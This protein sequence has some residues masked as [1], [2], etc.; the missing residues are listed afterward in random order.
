MKV[1]MGVAVDLE[2]TVG[3][4]FALRKTGSIL[5]VTE[6]KNFCL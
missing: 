1:N 2:M 6:R 4:I 5:S 3:W